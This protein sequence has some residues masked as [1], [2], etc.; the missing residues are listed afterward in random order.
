MKIDTKKLPHDIYGVLPDWVIKSYIRKQVIKVKNLVQGWEKDVDQ[1]S[2]D[3]H[4][5]NRF[6]LPAMGRH[7]VIDTRVGVSK[8]MYQ[9][10]ILK[11]GEPITLRPNQ[12]MI[13][14]TKEEFNLPNDM[15]GRLEGKSSF[16]RL[17]VV[18]HQ[19][20]ARFDPGWN[21]P[22]VLEIRNNSDNDIILYCGDK[23]CALSFERMMLPVENPYIKRNGSKYHRNKIMYSQ[24][25]KDS[26]KRK[27]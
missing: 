8:P 27:I 3:F 4:L 18:I 17:G 9:E 12:F 26:S 21:G 15:I 11:N 20:S 23:I 10:F 6:M 24:I 22:A 5:G 14:Q 1:V 25:H 16:A 2:I 13:A 7:I 19:T